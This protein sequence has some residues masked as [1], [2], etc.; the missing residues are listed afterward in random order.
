MTRQKFLP[1]SGPARV[2]AALRSLSETR[3]LRK[4]LLNGILWDIK[5]PAIYKL[6]QEV[7]VKRSLVRFP[8]V[9]FALIG[10]FI[11]ALVAAFS[12]PNKSIEWHQEYS[13]Y[14]LQLE[15]KWE[16]FG[17]Q[18][19]LHSQPGMPDNSTD[20]SMMRRTIVEHPE[21]GAFRSAMSING[22]YRYWHGYQAF[23]RPLLL[24][25]QIHQLRWLGQF[26]FHGLLLA[27]LLLLRRR[28]LSLPWLFL[29]VIL[30]GPV[31]VIP[32][33][34]QFMPAFGTMFAAVIYVL[35]CAP[36]RDTQ[37]AAMFFMIVGML[38][39]YLDL[40]T[41][42]LITLGMPLLLC[43]Y[44]DDESSFSASVRRF[45]AS[46]FSWGM[47]YGLCW[48]FKWLLAWLCGENTLQDA[49][50]NHSLFWIKGSEKGVNR[51]AVV[52]KNFHNFFLQHGVRAQIFILIPVVILLL[53]MIRY[54]VRLK[55]AF[56]K[57]CLFIPVI[58]SPYLWYF[59][60]AEHSQQHH[61]FTYRAQ[62]V[63][64]WGIYLMLLSLVD[65]KKLY[66]KHQK[67][68]ALFERNSI[69]N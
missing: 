63:T 56:R 41:T 35:L 27:I 36:Q 11:L 32:T 67:L 31:T 14:I 1:F 37:H 8:I 33:S 61:W 23:L 54:P 57:A 66:A 3:I 64:L 10:L 12:I 55:S 47:G 26:V 22:Y 24:F 38:T 17:N 20:R 69:P 58:L 21:Q 6:P 30:C 39:S 34:L 50:F 60:L 42:P 49:V 15:E 45:L 52:G 46:V 16:S 9:F 51:L 68:S 19:G 25:F 53:L 4:G 48:A 28:S 13:M 62:I 5:K 43:V 18:Y 59:I 65:R 44:L 40:L 29:A 2:S 7:R